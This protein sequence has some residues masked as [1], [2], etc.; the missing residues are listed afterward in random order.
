MRNYVQEGKTLTFT[1]PTGGVVSGG[2]YM[3]GG[4]FVVA[5]FAAAQT[6]P[7]EGDVVGVFDLPKATA[8]AFAEGER[9][10]WDNTAKQIKKTAS[11]YFP[12]GFAAAAA[13][14]ADTS[15]PVRLDGVYVAA[16]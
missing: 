12:I 13:I 10:F 8:I 5:A 16:V 3:I 15:L 2:G 6:L 7:F 4:A 14:N 9:V 1:A 11:G